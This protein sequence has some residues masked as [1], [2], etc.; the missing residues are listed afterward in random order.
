MAEEINPTDK[1]TLQLVLQKLVSYAKKKNNMLADYEVIDKIESYGLDSSSKN[2]VYKYF[3]ENGI[4]II[5][6]NYDEK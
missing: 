3:D 6:A 1:A 4:K 5:E 2:E